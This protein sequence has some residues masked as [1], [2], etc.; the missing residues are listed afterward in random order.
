VAVRFY[1]FIF[2]SHF[3]FS[4]FFFISLFYFLNPPPPPP[5]THTLRSN[6][7]KEVAEAIKH[8]SATLQLSVA[9]RL[10]PGSIFETGR[11]LAGIL[12]GDAQLDRAAQVWRDL[13]RMFPDPALGAADKAAAL[14]ARARQKKGSEN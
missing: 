1:L 10:E 2:C 14:E 12:E 5:H 11:D 8:M 13:A 6:V 9:Q 7:R 4:H 3:F